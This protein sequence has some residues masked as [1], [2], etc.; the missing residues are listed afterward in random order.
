MPYRDYDVTPNA[1]YTYRVFAHN[2]CG[3]S[4]PSNLAT[5]TAICP[6]CGGGCFIATAAY[7]SYLD[8]HVQTLRDFRDGYLRPN[9]L[10]SGFV[11]TYY[12]MSPPVAEFIV[13]HPGVKPA[14]RVALLPA[15]GVSEAAVGIGLGAKL[16]IAAAVLLVSVVG[17]AWSRR[18]GVGADR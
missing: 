4:A 13:D 17:V 16:A 12:R 8:N 18:G 1:T 2:A 7:G 11:S 5:A 6:V 15:V 14:V 9:P 10:G 3:D